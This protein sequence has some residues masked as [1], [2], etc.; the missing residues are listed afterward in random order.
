MSLTQVTGNGLEHGLINTIGNSVPDDGLKRFAE[1]DRPEMEKK[2]KNDEKIVKFQY[3]NSR[4]ATERYEAP[5]C[6]WA[7]QPIQMWR[8]L[9]GYTYEG[10]KGMVDE[11]NE[12]PAPTE[13]S[14][15]LDAK[16]NPTVKNVSADKLHRCIPL[17]F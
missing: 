17:S 12:M 5:Y 1:K 16:G 4:G 15:L 2:K 6:K 3:L 9:H 10:P 7:G 11:I 8:L 14:D 13:F